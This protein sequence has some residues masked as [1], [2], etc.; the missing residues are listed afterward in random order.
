MN[1]DTSSPYNMP[2]LSWIY[3]Y[4]AALS[5][6]GLIALGLLVFFRRKGWLG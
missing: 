5:L 2:E 6:M 3:G 1:F 4:P